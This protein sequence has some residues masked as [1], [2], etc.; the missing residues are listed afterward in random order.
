MK[1]TNEPK[2]GVPLRRCLLDFPLGEITVFVR[3]DG[4]LKPVQPVVPD[5]EVE[6][7][8]THPSIYAR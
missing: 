2:I 3:I 7:L 8:V 5:V 4:V 1:S 6:S